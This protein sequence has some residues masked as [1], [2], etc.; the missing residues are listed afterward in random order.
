[1]FI[2]ANIV[3]NVN[4]ERSQFRKVDIAFSKFHLFVFSLLWVLGKSFFKAPKAPLHEYFC[5]EMF[6]FA[7]LV[8]KIDS[9]QSHLFSES[10]G[11]CDTFSVFGFCCCCCCFFFLVCGVCGRGAGGRYYLVKV[12][13][14]YEIWLSFVAFWILRIFR[15]F[16]VELEE[17]L[18]WRQLN[19]RQYAFG[20]LHCRIIV[21]SKTI[22]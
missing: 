20:W 13:G 1:M 8:P 17:A 5:D 6:L 21:H 22:F 14:K 7:N 18:N 3:Q 12:L 16:W 9:E 4:F 15:N 19:W 10:K 2:F 11:E